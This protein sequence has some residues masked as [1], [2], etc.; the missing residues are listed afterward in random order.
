MRLASGLSADNAEPARGVVGGSERAGRLGAR[1]MVAGVCRSGRGL[2]RFLNC[3]ALPGEE[4]A[5]VWGPT[6]ADDP[7]MG[8][9]VRG[10]SVDPVW[11][12]ATRER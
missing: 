3:S 6:G 12:T 5:G 2:G 11:R 10:S 4:L 8:M 7:V 1:V 9:S